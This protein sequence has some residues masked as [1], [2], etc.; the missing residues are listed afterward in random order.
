MK[1]EE[2]L[3][4]VRPHLRD[5][6]PYSSA[7][8]EFD[9][10]AVE[11]NKFIYLDANENPFDTGYNR[12]PDPYQ[13]DLKKKVSSIKDIPANQIFLGN[14]SDEAIDLII[15]LFCGEGDNIL[16]P[17]PTYG[18][19]KVSA[20]IN[21]ITVKAQSLT[22]NFQLPQSFQPDERTR[23]VFLC[24][25]NNP[26]GNLLDIHLQNFNCI[27]VVDEAYIDFTSNPSFT[28]KLDQF[29][30][31][32]VLQTLSKA[33]GL[34]GLRLGMAFARPEVISLLNKIKPPYN[35]SSATQQIALKELQ[36]DNTSIVQKIIS[37]R[38]RLANELLKIKTIK[39]VYPSDA[40]FL[41]VKIDDAGNVYTNLIIDGI[42]VR[43]RSRVK[44]CDDCLRITIGTPEENN[45]LLEALKSAS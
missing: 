19:Y 21:N 23:V 11:K 15:R 29:P 1:I 18:M 9:Q 2:V 3:S 4:L 12:Y 27:V 5:L 28:K 13:H 37:E 38:T 25:P 34:A 36:K 42:V 44:L 14:G 17:T 24:S 45:R 10:S 8:D 35:I 30:N 41:L 40:N 31:L 22:E 32:I 26:S 43:D 20:D 33:W 39:K 6:Q 7:R 16:I